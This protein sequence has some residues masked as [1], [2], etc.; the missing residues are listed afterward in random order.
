[1]H[2]M[3]IRRPQIPHIRSFAA[4]VA[5]ASCAPAAKGPAAQVSAPQGQ[6][7]QGELAPVYQKEPESG[8]TLQGTTGQMD[9]AE[10]DARFKEAL[11]EFN[12]CYAETLRQKWFLSGRLSLKLRVGEDGA[13]RSALVSGSTVGS[14][15]VER[16]VQKVAGQIRFPRPKGGEGE[17]TYPVEFPA[18]AAVAAWPEA[19][20]ASQMSRHAREVRTCPGKAPRPLRLT[21]YIGPGGKV[22][23]AGLSAEEPIED[24]TGACLIARAQGWR[25]DDTLG[26]LVK[27]S[28]DFD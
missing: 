22:A 3:M 21:V 18:K 19:R 26:Q 15:E 1:M 28:Y 9:E 11:P 27:A 25:F 2:V 10:I 16:C 12:R 7:K 14:Y 5:L 13:V 4:L 6:E 24:R 17:L 20:V 23:S 8:M